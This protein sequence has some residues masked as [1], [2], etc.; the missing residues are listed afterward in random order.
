M[1]TKNSRNIPQTLEVTFE[2]IEKVIIGYSS[3]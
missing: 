3:S 1:S 2:L